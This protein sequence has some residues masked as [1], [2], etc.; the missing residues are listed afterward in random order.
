MLQ[1]KINVIEAVCEDYHSYV[2]KCRKV[3]KAIGL[4]NHS[5]KSFIKCIY[6]SV[7]DLQHMRSLTNFIHVALKK[8]L[9]QPHLLGIP[10]AE[11][12][13][14]LVVVPNEDHMLC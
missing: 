2:L 8:G 4:H 7:L 12:R 3:C 6:H 13:L 5:C 1:R 14:Q 9:S 10:V 11:N